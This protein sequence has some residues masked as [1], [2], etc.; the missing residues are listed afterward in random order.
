MQSMKASNATGLSG[1]GT[2]AK[3][4]DVAPEDNWNLVGNPTVYMDVLP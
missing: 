2:H 1:G 3:A 4:A